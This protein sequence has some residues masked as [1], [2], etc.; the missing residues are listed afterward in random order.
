MQSADE[1]VRLH[2]ESLGVTFGDEMALTKVRQRVLDRDQPL[3]ARQEGLA[4]LLGAKDPK[5][6]S[7]LSELLDDS[8]MRE[9]ALGGLA[10]VN[11][12]KTAEWILSRYTDYSP[13]EKRTALATLSARAESALAMLKAVENKKI[14]SNELS[15]D[16][17]RQL[18][19]LNHAE[20]N[21][22]L[23]KTWV[24]VR[25]TAADKARLIDEYKKLASSNKAKPD[26]GHGRAVFAR[27]C[28]QCHAL[29]GVGGNV[30]PDLTVSNRTNL[31][32]LL[33]NIVDPSALWP[34]VPANHSADQ[35]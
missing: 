6:A 1:Q 18:Q 8:A 15:A 24:T 23:T 34:R 33:S 10:Q 21:D 30:G 16:L 17:V 35:R 20:V 14:A 25:E 2:A 4:S 28:Q 19:N 7:L 22:L 3:A 13:T 27:T 29:F 31:D 5:L 32:Y 11:D 12:S 9:Q 26:L